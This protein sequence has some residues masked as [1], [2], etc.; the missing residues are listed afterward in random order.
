MLSAKLQRLTPPQP[1]CHSVRDSSWIIWRRV[2]AKHYIGGS[3]LVRANSSAGSLSL[4]E[5]ASG[6]RQRGNMTGVKGVYDPS[7]V[8]LIK[9][10][11]ETLIA[12]QERDKLVRIIE[13][14]LA[15]LHKRIARTGSRGRRKIRQRQAHLDQ[16][17]MLEQNLLNQLYELRLGRRPAGL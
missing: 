14:R 4:R 13:Q 7:D 2:V 3:S 9:G 17:R 1:V 5:L 11:R 8:R 15:S 16:L 6:K 12:D 10:G